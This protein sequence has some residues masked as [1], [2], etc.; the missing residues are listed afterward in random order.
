MIAGGCQV[1][2]GLAVLLHLTCRT[3]SSVSHHVS[4]TDVFAHPAASDAALDETARTNTGL[5]PAA[6]RGHRRYVDMLSLSEP[7]AKAAAGC[8]W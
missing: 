4:T 2:E 3:R 1:G 8:R 7:A 6:R 5:L